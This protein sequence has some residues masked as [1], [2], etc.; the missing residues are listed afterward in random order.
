[1][2]VTEVLRFEALDESTKVL[3]GIIGATVQL[4]KSL[5]QLG[6]DAVRSNAEVERS[7]RRLFASMQART[8]I[9]REA[10]QA[11]GAFN[12]SLEDQLGLD[13]DHLKQLQGTLSLQD[14]ANSELER[15]TEITIGL[16]EITGSLE[17]SQRAVAQAY[18]GNFRAVSK[19]LPGVDTLGELQARGAELFQISAN[20]ADDF[21]SQLERLKRTYE[22]TNEA[23]GK[24]ATLNHTLGGATLILNDVLEVYNS[25]IEKNES[26]IG[27]SITALN[28]LHTQILGFNI[29]GLELWTPS[30]EED[31]AALR[32]EKEDADAARVALEALARV[33]STFAEATGQPDFGDEG[34]TIPSDPEK[35]KREHDKR[36]KERQKEIEEL[37]K[38]GAGPS[39]DVFS[40]IQQDQADAEKKS[41]STFVGPSLDVFSQIQQDQ[42]DE[43][44]K[45]EEKA[46][47]EREKL[48]EQHGKKLKQVSQDTAE[49]V[50][51]SASD[52]ANSI[53]STGIAAAE[54]S[55]TGEEAFKRLATT[56]VAAAGQIISSV[57]AQSAA[58]SASATTQIIAHGGITASKEAEK[59]SQELPW[60]ISTAVIPGVIAFVTGLF[61]TLLSSFA[62]GGIA[63]NGP[64]LPNGEVLVGMTP[65]ERALTP[66]QTRS[67]DRLVEAIAGPVNRASSAAPARSATTHVSVSYQQLFPERDANFRRSTHKT[68]VPA[69]RRAVRAGASLQSS[70][71]YGPEG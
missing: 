7:D 32:K 25:K 23:I 18:E 11:L 59:V 55:I 46:L 42:V 26:L 6:V 70:R 20:N 16:T 10:F 64:L 58:T 27:A 28:Q 14:V 71:V 57:F 63:R 5:V 2:T 31:Q 45:I 29:P 43:A 35:A 37:R 12:D 40:Q 56:A 49:T 39:L 47:K 4:S 67:F 61:A 50:I 52:I 21:I 44:K 13:A 9:T 22:N 41:A 53:L 65:G 1:M 66:H 38:L 24:N 17:K 51:S 60:P 15:A 19:L 3:D 34:D 48:Y 8:G 30:L 54:G 36:V 68:V 69:L 33:R 62:S